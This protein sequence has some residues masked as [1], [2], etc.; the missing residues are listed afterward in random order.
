MKNSL[1]VLQC[2]RCVLSHVM[3]KM[4]YGLHCGAQ[5]TSQCEME[6][7]VK[8]VFQKCL[9]L[10]TQRAKNFPEKEQCVKP[11]PFIDHAASG[12][13]HNAVKRASVE[14]LLKACLNLTDDHHFVAS[15]DQRYTSNVGR[16]HCR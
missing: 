10:D 4:C 13:C 3:Y 2:A 14:P 7:L 8:L 12:N 5:K 6:T 9:S 16:E 15:L 1:H 11:S